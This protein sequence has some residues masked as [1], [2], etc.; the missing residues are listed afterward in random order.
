L[1]HREFRE[2]AGLI[3][4]AYQATIRHPN[5]DFL[6]GLSFENSAH[7]E[8]SSEPSALE[9][10]LSAYMR[11]LSGEDEVWV[12]PLIEG[13]RSWNGLVRMGTVLN[14]LGQAK[15]ALEAFVLAAHHS[16]E[17][18]ADIELGKAESLNALGRC[19]EALAILLPLMED[20]PNSADVAILAAESCDILGQHEASQDFWNLAIRCAKENLEGLHR[21]QRLNAR[22]AA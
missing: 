17:I 13:I 3:D 8:L 18:R 16:G 21:L 2:V 14:C 20:A 5:L 19:E 12:D 4:Q 9:S 15:D 7:S 6:R 11:V 22:F 10:A 1:K